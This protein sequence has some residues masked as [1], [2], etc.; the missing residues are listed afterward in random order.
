MKR[1]DA[2][3]SII[4]GFQLGPR[5]HIV[6]VTQL[7]RFLTHDRER[8]I[9]RERTADRHHDGRRTDAVFGDESSGKATVRVAGWSAEAARDRDRRGH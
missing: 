7:D 2:R 4:N 9:E 8:P 6:T 5:Q 3:W 1:H